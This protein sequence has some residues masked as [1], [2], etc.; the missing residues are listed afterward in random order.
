MFN[1][2]GYWMCKDFLKDIFIFV[3]VDQLLDGYFLMMKKP[4][5]SLEYAKRIKALKI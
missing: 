2:D 1:K 4:Y 3:I 5:K